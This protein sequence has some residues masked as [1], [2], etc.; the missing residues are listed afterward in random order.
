MRAA[1]YLR[2]SQDRDGT[3][4]GVERQR[5]DC[6]TH[7]QTLGWTI[8]HTLIDDDLSAYSG[9]PRPAYE[10]LLTLIERGDIGAVVAWHPDR[11]HRSPAELERFIDLVQRM[12][13]KVATV[14]AGEL[15]LGTAAGRMTARVVG[16]VARHES[17]QK[18]ERLRRQRAQAALAGKPHG[19]RRP[20]GWQSDRL[21][22]DPLEAAA[23]RDAADR[24]IAGG[25]VRSIATEWN[26]QGIRPVGGGEWWA[27]NVRN[28]LVSPR[29]AGLRVHHG[30][31]VAQGAWAPILTRDEHDLLCASLAVRT[32]RG[33]KPASLLSGL[34][35][36]G[37]CGGRLTHDTPKGTRRYVCV[38]NPG[39]QSGCRLSIAAAPV[40]EHITDAV[41]AVATGPLTPPPRSKPVRVDVGA[42]EERLARLAELYAAGGIGEAEWLRARNVIDGQIRDA[43]VV[44]LS[45]V[46]RAKVGPNLADRWAELDV[47]ER[48]A[49]I[50]VFVDRVTVA[51]GDRSDGY[52]RPV[53]RLTIL[54]AV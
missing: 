2:I 17:E 43:Q 24:I 28:L 14:R 47:D 36:C 33:R 46:R 23:I 48:R 1:L 27:R 26:A 51:P 3:L 10:T 45:E 19:G 42:L 38:A 32:A 5:E 54:W 31:V 53:E 29:L 50:A 15:D 13:C 16:A 4:L 44:D 8:A 9:K 25:S 21:T 7:A 35:I 11:L 52:R 22:L 12:D 39:K 6:E 41:L 34:L 18:S 49:T 20:F 37:R 30:Q 40:E